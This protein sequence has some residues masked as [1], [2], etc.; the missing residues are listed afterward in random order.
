MTQWDIVTIQQYY[1]YNVSHFNDFIEQQQYHH[2]QFYKQEDKA[3]LSV[4]FAAHV[5]A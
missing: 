1:T 3:K 2:L 4:K 5:N